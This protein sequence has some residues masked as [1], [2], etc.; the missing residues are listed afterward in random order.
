[1]ENLKKLENFE[2]FT[3]IHGLRKFFEEGGGLRTPG[4]GWVEG[5]KIPPGHPRWV[6]RP[7]RGGV[8]QF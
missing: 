6:R 2:I 3:Y 1:M 5:V 4:L 7:F 8:A